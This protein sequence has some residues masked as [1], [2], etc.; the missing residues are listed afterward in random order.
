MDG[1]GKRTP[2]SSVKASPKF[3]I[4]LRMLSFAFHFRNISIDKPLATSVYELK[5]FTTI[6]RHLQGP[7]VKN[8]QGFQSG[9]LTK[10]INNLSSFLEIISGREIII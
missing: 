6:A 3:Q 7:K 5:A 4:M 8:V 1:D 9:V 10:E 2:N